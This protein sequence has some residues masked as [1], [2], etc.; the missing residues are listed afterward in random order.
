MVEWAGWMV[1]WTPPGVSFG[2]QKKVTR[3]KAAPSKEDIGV[4]VLF[5][6]FL[7]VNPWFLIVASGFCPFFGIA[8]K[9]EPKKR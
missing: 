9:K 8:P 7:V 1:Y 6:T 2:R 4:K 5:F 3:L